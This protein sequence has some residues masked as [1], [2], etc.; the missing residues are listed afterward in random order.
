MTRS[1][2]ASVALACLV[3]AV[4]CVDSQKLREAFDPC[5]SG[6]C[7]PPPPQDCA[8]LSAADWAV[9]G[10]LT[11]PE[12]QVPLDGSSRSI[13]SPTVES[14]CEG[15]VVSVTWHAD[16]PTVVSLSPTGRS[17]WVTGL[18]L[19]LT[20]LG[21]TIAFVDGVSREARGRPVRVVPNAPP[22]GQIVVEGDLTIE[23]YVPPGNAG[24]SWS[25][26]VPFTTTSTGRIDVV[27]DWE[28]PV[29]R[30]D[31]SGYEGHCAAVGACGPIR[32]TL[33]E[34]DVKPLHATFDNPRTPP[35]D[36]TIRIDNLGPSEET[37]HYEVRLTPS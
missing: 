3:T 6:G 18:T 26:W 7:V 10:F 19:G 34:H 14:T 33:R 37:V 24:P 16:D 20:S 5:A 12:S 2:P 29:D 8:S 21:A 9:D 27:V 22:Q 1:R 15:V 36:F 32:L 11:T 30:I 28:S 13:L 25:G 23:P 35:G 4:G 31:F 17:V